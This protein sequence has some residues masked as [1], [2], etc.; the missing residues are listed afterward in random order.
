MN[1]RDFCYW[2]NGFFDL[3][4]ENSS[5]SEEQVK[6][7][8]DHLSLVFNK[9]VKSAQERTQINPQT[10]TNHLTNTSYF[11]SLLLITHFS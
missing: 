2:L 8:K 10:L 6:V 7:I 3:S 1:E 4:E 9:K 11:K 5:L